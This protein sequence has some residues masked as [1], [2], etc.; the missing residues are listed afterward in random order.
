MGFTG[1]DVGQLIVD[2][3]KVAGKE[4]IMFFLTN[5]YIISLIAGIIVSLI[6]CGIVGRVSYNWYRLCGYSKREAKNKAKRN[7]MIA[8]MAM[9]AK[10]LNSKEN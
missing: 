8:D 9:S 2:A 1:T 7:K 5:K 3:F 4:S 10:D 6:V